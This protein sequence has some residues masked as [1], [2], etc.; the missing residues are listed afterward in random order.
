M[1]QDE[2]PSRRLIAPELEPLL[3]VF[4]Q[5]DFS[6][7]VEAWRGSALADMQPALREDLAA[8]EMTE[9]SVPGP[10]GAPEIRL[11]IYRPPG[12]GQGPHPVLLNIHGG[13]YVIGT[14]EQ[15]DPI[16]RARALALG[17]PIVATSYRLA[18]RPRFP[19]PSRIVTRPCAGSRQMRTIWASMPRAS[20]F[21]VRARAG[22][23]PRR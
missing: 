8:V 9:R 21:R 15:N 23:T 20:R 13:G 10:E 3:D 12:L 17:C 6:Q 11:L 4:P 2:P 19:V 5:L 7:G 22:D 18:P 14:P 1:P 16:N